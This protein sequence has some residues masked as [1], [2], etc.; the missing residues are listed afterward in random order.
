M[1][2]CVCPL[3]KFFWKRLCP[4]KINI[5]NWLAWKDRILTLEKLASRGC[6]RLPMA[7]CVLCHAAIESVDHLFL[8][9]SLARQVWWYFG[10]LLNLLGPPSALHLI[11]DRWR[12]SVRPDCRD[13]GDLVVKSIVWNIWLARNDYMFN[14]TVVYAHALIL[15]IDRMLL[16]WISTAAEGPTSKLEEHSSTIRQSLEFHNTSVE[17][18]G[19]VPILE[20]GRDLHTG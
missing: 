5:F 9:C 11:W 16:T 15:K 1:G 13:I 14:A 10:R 18:S 4:K 2:D 8:H 6:N 19:D 12:S 17:G 3:A 20:G 7:T